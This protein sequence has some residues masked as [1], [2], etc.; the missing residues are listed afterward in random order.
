[1]SQRLFF[2]SL[3]TRPSAIRTEVEYDPLA[4]AAGDERR[5]SG[6]ASSVTTNESI[7]DPKDPVFEECI[8]QFFVE[9]ANIP[10]VS[11][12]RTNYEA[13]RNIIETTH[14]TPESKHASKN[15]SNLTL[16]ENTERLIKNMGA[17]FPEIVRI[18]FASGG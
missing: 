4:A 7:F 11:T 13:K 5:T 2:C 14:L 17:N 18:N 3:E 9:V 8:D 1:M 6:A 16:I 15:A 10:D 12:L